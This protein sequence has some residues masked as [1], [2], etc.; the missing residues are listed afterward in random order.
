[1][2]VLVV[3]ITSPSG[4]YH[5]TLPISEQAA[6]DPARRGHIIRDTAFQYPNGK[7]TSWKVLDGDRV[8]AQSKM[9][10]GITAANPGIADHVLEDP[11][12]F[13]PKVEADLQEIIEARKE[14][15]SQ[16][17]ATRAQVGGIVAL[18]DA[19]IYNGGPSAP[20]KKIAAGL[21]ERRANWDAAFQVGVEHATKNQLTGDVI[22]AFQTPFGDGGDGRDT[23]LR[24]AYEAGYNSVVNTGLTDDQRKRLGGVETIQGAEYRAELLSAEFDKPVW[25]V[26]RGSNVRP[27]FATIEGF[28]IGDYVSKGYNGD[29]YP[30]G[31]IIGMSG[32][33]HPVTG[34][35]IITVQTPDMREIKFW[36]RRTSDSWKEGNADGTFGLVKGVR[37]QRN[38]SF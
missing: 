33:G 35:R 7:A 12:D 6:H 28:K 31:R 13:T 36:R 2:H 30:V 10:D 3:E 23:S 5:K 9:K 26:D 19:P 18:R 32:L 4:D 17:E 38:P 14:A 25:A 29:I 34:F 22:S 11:F 16:D 15:I 20:E 1:M 24:D 37:D 21:E 8:I 27:R